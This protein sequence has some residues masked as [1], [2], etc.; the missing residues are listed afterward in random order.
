MTSSGSEKHSSNLE[1]TM[2][3]TKKQKNCYRSID[4]VRKPICRKKLNTQCELC[5][6]ADIRYNIKRQEILQ[7]RKIKNRQSAMKSRDNRSLKWDDLKTDNFLLEDE[8]W[9]AT[10]ELAAITWENQ[11]LVAEIYKKNAERTWRLHQ[12]V[13]DVAKM[14]IQHPEDT[15]THLHSTFGTVMTNEQEAI[16]TT[17]QPEANDV[18]P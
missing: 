10:N 12:I 17:V 13:S 15:I 3:K 7:N 1:R 5:E 2:S 16:I 6:Q 18:S 11:R 14:I 9:Q 8:K 4:N